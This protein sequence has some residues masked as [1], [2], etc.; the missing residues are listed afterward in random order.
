MTSRAS[1]PVR[2]N[3]LN[4]SSTSRSATIT[5]VIAIGP[6]VGES[7][8]VSLGDDGWLIV[9]SCRHRDG[10]PQALRYLSTR[11]VAPE[12]VSMVVCT[13]W[14]DDH[15]KGMGEVVEACTNADFVCTAAVASGDFLAIVAASEIGGSTTL[16]PGVAE[17]GR[18]LRALKA[19][20]R[21]LRFASSD[22]DLLVTPNA[23]VRALAPG[24]A[25]I[26]IGLEA[27]GTLFP[28]EDDPKSP[29]PRPRPGQNPASIVLHVIVGQAHILLGGDLEDSTD[30]S[31]GW[32]AILDSPSRTGAKASLFK[33]PHHGSPDAHNLRVWAELL[34]TDVVAVVT[35]YKS[36]KRPRSED[37]ARILSLAPRAFVT[38]SPAHSRPVRRDRMVEQ[39][40]SDVVRW[41]QVVDGEESYAHF[42]LN[43]KSNTW[44][45]QCVGEAQLLQT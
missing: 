7:I 32:L 44:E 15:M 30:P 42:R 5:E 41:T 43:Q 6:G 8:V 22:R 14:H 33:V 19:T 18:V 4:I 29:P 38:A 37:S 35:P 11:G 27:I 3:S 40:L 39:M 2:P 12:E 45:V 36:S 34:T 26:R 9:D 23:S 20:G 13:H 31:R 1:R 17:F 21:K 25:D 16:H 10:T 28:R 24:D